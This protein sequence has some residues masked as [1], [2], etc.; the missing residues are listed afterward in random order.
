[1]EQ[2]LLQQFI[3]WVIHHGGLYVLLIIIFAETGLFLGFFLPGDSL[4]FAAGIY[5]NELA[6]N[7]Y[8]VHFLM[9]IGL[10]VAASFVGS[11]VGYW[12]GFRT[13]PRMFKW[14]DWFLYKKKYLLK[15]RDF[16]EHHGKSTVFLSK[17]LPVIRTFAPLVAGI[18]QMPKPVFIFYNMAGSIVW[19][20]S[21]I[22][23]GHF[24]QAFIEK[25][26]GFSLKDH[27]ELITVL[28]ILITTL[29]VI[30]KMIVTKKE[31]P[32]QQKLE[33]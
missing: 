18:V 9:A 1:M 2:G 4:L 14:K 7:F 22:F 31:K 16:Y 12:I 13:G 10:V 15:A 30:Y 23:G 3:E 25:K 32:L 28:I 19:V 20:A 6:F 24:L 26:Y 11:M 17:F 8:H 27:I 29:P 21:M 5:I 33:N